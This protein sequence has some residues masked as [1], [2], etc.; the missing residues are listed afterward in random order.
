MTGLTY[1]SVALFIC[2]PGYYFTGAAL[3]ICGTDGEWSGIAG[4]CKRK[5]LC[6]CS[7]CIVIYLI[8]Y[9][10]PGK[11][12]VPQSIRCN[13]GALVYPTKTAFA[14]IGDVVQYSVPNGY[15]FIG[16]NPVCQPN[17]TWSASPVCLSKWER[18]WMHS[19]KC[20]KGVYKQWN[21]LLDWNTGPGMDYQTGI[22]LVSTHFWLA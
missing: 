1:F 11:C 7:L 16:N 8:L 3:R 6:L 20:V 5:L 17:S 21:G 2:D 10:S 14:D 22:F 4:I 19:A 12:T 13:D 18:L 9:S 15:G